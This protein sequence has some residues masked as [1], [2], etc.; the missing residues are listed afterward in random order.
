M[1][2]DKLTEVSP[3]DLLAGK[4]RIE[5]VLGQGGMGVVVAAIHEALDERVALKFLLPEALTNQEAVARFTRE[6]RAAVKIRSEYVARVTDVG[7]LESGS[8]YMVME[9]LQGADLSQYLERTGPLPIEEAIEY[10]LQ[11]CE[12]LAEAHSLGI[13]HRDLKPANLFRIVRPDGTPAIKL[14]DFGISKLTSANQ[15][16]T[17]TS[18]MMGSPLYMAPEQM[19][20]AKHV[21]MRAD[22]WAVG[23]ILHELLTAQ[24]PF[25]GDTLPE[26][27]AKILTEEP[28]PLRQLRPDAPQALE[29]VLLTCL[30]KNRD[31]RYPNIA[32]LAAD[33][34]PF[35]PARA[36][37][38]VDRVSRVLGVTASPEPAPTAA[39]AEALTSEHQE[40][41]ALTQG[42]WGKTQSGSGRRSSFGAALVAIALLVAGGATATLLVMRSKSEPPNTAPP[43]GAESSQVAVEGAAAPTPAPEPSAVVTAQT[44]VEPATDPTPPAEAP[45]P[46]V[47]PSKAAAAVATAA[48]APTSK[49]TT[50]PQ[51]SATTKTPS[52][53]ATTAT[54][55]QQ[56]PAAAKKPVDLYSDRK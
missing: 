9:Y 31:E 2:T 47:T 23:V 20:S 24:V 48:P 55:A 46:E 33:L 12:A 13:V 25:G 49:S 43:A 5:R 54:P 53:A 29:Q 3:G 32:A 4:Y 34:R 35:A 42:A 44:Q 22:I 11:A 6:A 8:P 52:K 50:A 40:A 14:L 39:P 38:S 1:G 19:T 41:R 15:S 45:E 16:M 21:D 28:P 17:Q 26:L 7:T 30:R 36:Q 18:S 10:V 27:C 56:A 51:K 37:H